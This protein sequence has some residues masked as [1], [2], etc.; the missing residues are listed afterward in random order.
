MKII[1][2]GAL[3]LLSA[4]VYAEVKTYCTDSPPAV[5]LYES[6]WSYIDLDLPSATILL[7]VNANFERPSYPEIDQDFIIQAKLPGQQFYSIQENQIIDPGKV[8]SSLYN[9]N[10]YLINKRVYGPSTIRI[11]APVRAGVV[12]KSICFSY[13]TQD[14][15][16][17]DLA[18]G[19]T[20][21]D[22]K[23]KYKDYKFGDDVLLYSVKADFSRNGF[24]EAEMDFDLQFSSENTFQSL[25][26]N[27]VWNYDSI[28]SSLYSEWLLL[29][30]K[31]LIGPGTLRFSGPTGRGMTWGKTCVKTFDLSSKPVAIKVIEIKKSKKPTSSLTLKKYTAKGENIISGAS[32]IR[33]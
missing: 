9:R 25:A 13:I 15:I 27:Q 26:N 1:M 22:D 16:C 2:L 12:W 3:N 31:E 24:S 21:Y 29:R 11:S 5:A 14:S 20:P 18:D 32:Q 7:W 4:S 17:S 23:W 30:E 8:D 33:F 19:V 6:N 28:A 10:L